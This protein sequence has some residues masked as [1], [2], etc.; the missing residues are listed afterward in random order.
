MNTVIP[1]SVASH[2]STQAV[3]IY[4]GAQSTPFTLALSVAAPGVFTVNR[5]GAGQAVV[6]NQDGSVN[7]TS[8]A[9]PRGSE[10]ALYATAV[11]P[12]TPC[13]DGQVY[14]NNFPTATSPI[15]VG[16]GNIGAQVLYEGQAPYL[17]S[18]VTQINILIPSDAPTGVVPLTLVVNGVS[19][20]N[21]VTIAVK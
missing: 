8:N 7:G 1:C 3:V 4:Q 16:V 20:S 12:T 2:A 15:T 10:V 5:T 11:G 13:V 18:G 19:S 9:A 21:N 14:T 17:I 6:L